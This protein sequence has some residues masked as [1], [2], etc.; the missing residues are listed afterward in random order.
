LYKILVLVLWTLVLIF[1]MTG[2]ARDI[3]LAQVGFRHWDKIA[4]VGLFGVTGLV[5]VYGARF[6]R[7]FGWRLAFG[8]AFSL[9]L[10]FGTEFAQSFIK[11][12]TAD[13]YDLMADLLG[14]FSGLFV[15]LVAYLQEGLRSRLRL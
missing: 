9:F 3:P 11:Y 2:P 5:S 1:I 12:R 8:L 4:H 6:F 14:V 13:F 7:R 15:Y 10:A